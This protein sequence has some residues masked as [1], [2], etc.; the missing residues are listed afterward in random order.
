M[1]MN[2]PIAIVQVGMCCPVGLSTGESAASMRAG[3]TRKSATAFRDAARRPIIVGHLGDSLLP[4]L[5]PEQPEHPDRAPSG[6]QDRLLRLAVLPLREALSNNP[7]SRPLPLYLAGPDQ[8][9]QAEQADQADQAE[10]AE[11][12]APALL[13]RLASQ[14]DVDLDLDASRLFTAGRAGLFLALAAAREAL[15]TGRHEL[16]LVGGVDT[17]LDADRLAELERTRR[18][19]TSGPQ[20]AFVPGE[21]AAFL[22]LA[23]HETRRRLARPALASLLALGLGREPGHRYSDEPMLGDGLSAA[24]RAAFETLPE[25][26]EPIEPIELISS[27]L[28]GERGF[29]KEGAIALLRNRGQ[30]ADHVQL[31]HI[32][33]FIGDAGAASAALALALTAHRLHRR[34]LT[35]P[36]LVWAASDRAQRGAA[37]LGADTHT[38]P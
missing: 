10:Q 36:A 18:L 14:V 31:E 13:S 26:V 38:T 27:G 2:L 6:F 35:G 28:N 23:T 12:G 4:D 3:V 7:E 32:A 16:L 21:G 8:A 20:D 5:D 15:L 25:M 11:Q 9:D 17:Y 29:A 33:A 37:I 30:V 24:I 19:Q 1:N 22:L 34:L